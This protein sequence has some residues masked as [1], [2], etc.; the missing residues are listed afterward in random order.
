MQQ[1]KFYFKEIP[2]WAGTMDGIF[3]SAKVP[4]V[5]DRQL[6]PESEAKKSVLCQQGRGLRQRDTVFMSHCHFL[7][8]FPAKSDSPLEGIILRPA[9]TA[10]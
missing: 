10:Q 6:Q 7:S 3:A 5:G 8:P 4:E 1:L 9:H 2:I